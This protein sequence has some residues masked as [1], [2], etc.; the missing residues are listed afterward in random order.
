[1][2]I[3]LASAIGQQREPI[4]VFGGVDDAINKTGDAINSA[5]AAKKAAERRERDMALDSALS[6][7]STTIDAV[8]K[9]QETYRQTAAQGASELKNMWLNGAKKSEILL[10]T[11]ELKNVLEPMKI[12]FEDDAKGTAK[13]FTD[14]KPEW[15]KEENRYTSDKYEFS[16]AESI[17]TGVS[18]GQVPMSKDAPVR[19]MPVNKQDADVIEMAPM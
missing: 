8:P 4:S 11:Q 19:D 9:D 1:M 5:N 16:D 17:L 2:A 14:Y 15:N 13:F 10:K 12:R 7:I 18:R 6:S 3:K